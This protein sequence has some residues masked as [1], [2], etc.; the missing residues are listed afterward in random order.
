MPEQKQA[1]SLPPDIVARIILGEAAGEG[2]AGM[3]FVR[4]VLANRAKTQKKTL[5]EVGQPG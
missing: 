1:K 5:E 2:P 4:D 3:M